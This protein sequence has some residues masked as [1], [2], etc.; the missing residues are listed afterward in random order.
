MP[1][2]LSLETRHV[3]PKIAPILRFNGKIKRSIQKI[4]IY[5]MLHH[6]LT[7]IKLYYSDGNGSL[8]FYQST[9]LIC[10]SVLCLLK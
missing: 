1:I 3:H 10:G 4:Q 9:L 8:F 5:I 6:S 2:V 7:K